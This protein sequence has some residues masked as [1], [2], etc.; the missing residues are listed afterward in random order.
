MT[1]I[2]DSSSR[3]SEITSAPASS[4]SMISENKLSTLAYSLRDVSAGIPA[5]SLKHE[6]LINSNKNRDSSWCQYE[7]WQ[8]QWI[9]RSTANPLNNDWIESRLQTTSAMIHGLHFRANKPAVIV[10]VF[11]RVHGRKPASAA[12]WVW[13]MRLQSQ[14][15]SEVNI[16]W[17]P[18]W[19][20]LFSCCVHH[21]KQTNLT[22]KVRR[23][24]FGCPDQVRTLRC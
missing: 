14:N 21:I 3:R 22:F 18:S 11:I 24:M 15:G 17:F 13:M 12:C 23:Q 19:M 10:L 20:L 6:N 16:Q 4:K 5:Y 8:R 1:I 9:K 7:K 2:Q